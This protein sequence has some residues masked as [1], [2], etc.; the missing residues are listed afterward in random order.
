MAKRTALVLNEN[1]AEAALRALGWPTSVGLPEAIFAFQLGYN[2]GPELEPDGVVGPLTSAA[3]AAS[4]AAL[5]AG[6]PTAS[7]HFSFTEFACHCSGHYQG[8]HGL[9]V[10][11]DLL[12]SLEKLRAAYYA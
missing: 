11:R 6:K 5:K 4:L 3:L 7:A 1:E 12:D 10:R 2:L 9:L 8:C